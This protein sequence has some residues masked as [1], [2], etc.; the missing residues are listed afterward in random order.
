VTENTPTPGPATTAARIADFAERLKRLDDAQ[1]A[2]AEKQKAKGKNSAMARIMQ[3]VDPGTG[4]TEIDK[5]VRSRGDSFGDSGKRPDRDAVIM[6]VGRIHGRE[7][8]IFSQDFSVS[9]VR[10]AKR[11]ELKS[12]SFRNTP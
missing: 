5:F 9:A 1:K 4:F 11:P 8:G 3:L 6:G 12:S 10:S 2:A 7:V